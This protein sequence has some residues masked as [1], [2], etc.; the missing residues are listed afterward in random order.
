ML[1][2]PHATGKATIIKEFASNIGQF[3]YE[4][5]CKSFYTNTNLK[6]LINAG[7]MFGSWIIFKNLEQLSDDM[8]SY[9]AYCIQDISDAKKAEKLTIYHEGNEITISKKSS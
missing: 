4:I 1:I 2:G 9:L 6:H 7:I 3:I 8:L 5:D